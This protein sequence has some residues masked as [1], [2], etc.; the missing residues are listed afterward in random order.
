MMRNQKSGAAGPIKLG[1]DVM[2]KNDNWALKNRA[3]FN[4]KKVF[5]INLLSSPGSGKTTLLET[6]A[7]RF[8]R[9]MAV[10]AGDLQTPRDSERITRA[11]SPA[12]QIETGGACHLDAQ[13]VAEALTRLD[14]ETVKL[15]VI[16]NVGNLVCPAAYNLGEDIK[17]G[18]LSTA[19]GDDKVLKYPSIFSRI[20]V[21]LINKID[22]LPH[23]TFNPNKAVKECRSLNAS[24]KAFQISALTGEGVEAFFTYLSGQLDSI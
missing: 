3:L 22:L 15:A 21:L 5:C 16:E 19:E 20:D 17:V 23:L 2:S 1:A 6:M 8:G 14:L 4:G 12:V 11:G 24:V 9:E 10:V 18:M 7:G 13:S